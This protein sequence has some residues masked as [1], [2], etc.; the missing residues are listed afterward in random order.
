MRTVNSIIQHLVVSAEAKEGDVMDT[1]RYSPAKLI[2]LT[3]SDNPGVAECLNEIATTTGKYGHFQ[4]VRPGDQRK[5]FTFILA[6][7]HARIVGGATVNHASALT[8]V[9]VS[10]VEFKDRRSAPHRIKVLGIQVARSR[11]RG[12]YRGPTA[13]DNIF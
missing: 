11:S 9:F 4:I 5:C 2:V 7:P 1:L 6:V 13:D 8:C 3:S 12:R 10:E